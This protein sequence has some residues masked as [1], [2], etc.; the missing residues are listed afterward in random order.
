MTDTRTILE[1]VTSETFLLSGTSPADRLPGTATTG[2][3]QANVKTDKPKAESGPPVAVIGAVV[4][5]CLLLF[6]AGFTILLCYV[7]R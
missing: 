4:A 3:D 7:Q 6:I 5:A 1:S 2:T